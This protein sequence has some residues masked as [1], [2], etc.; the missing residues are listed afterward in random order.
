MRD[1]L[2]RLAEPIRL[3]I[4]RDSEASVVT[5]PK[6]TSGALS[7]PGQGALGRARTG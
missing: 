3:R 6:A 7:R 1:P 5:T 4:S 2:L